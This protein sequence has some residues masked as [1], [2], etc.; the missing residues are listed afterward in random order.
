M[1]TFADDRPWRKHPLYRGMPDDIAARSWAGRRLEHEEPA[2][3]R[4]NDAAHFDRGLDVDWQ[5]PTEIP[6]S[7][8]A[9]SDIMS[10]ASSSPTTSPR[11][12]P[13]AIDD[14]IV[15]AEPAWLIDG[16][17]PA[18]GLACIVGPPKSGKSFLTSDMVCAVARG[19][20]YAGRPTLQ[21]P[22]VY[23]TGEGLNG[24]KRRL[25]AMRRHHEI[26]GAGTPF[27]MIENVP[28]L[29][30]EQTDLPRLVAELDAFFAQ[31]APD[32]VRAI[33]LDTLA[34]CMGEADENSARDMGRFIT[35][36]GQLERRYNCLIIIVHHVGKDPS[37]GARGSN[38]INGA[39]DV[40]MIVEKNDAFSKVR[41]DEMKDGREGQEWRFRLVPYDLGATSE[42]GGS[43][44][45]ATSENSTCVV[46][47][48]SEPSQTQPRATKA[49]KPPAGVA[50][51]LLKVIRRAIEETGAANVGSAAVPNNIRA[52]SRA[53]VKNFCTTMAWQD[54]AEP[55][56]FRAM[57]SKTLSQLRDKGLIDFDREC[58]WLT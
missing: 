31:R 18:R 27:Y 8:D 51:D 12:V 43:T 53:T 35:R 20:S 21:G 39:A 23:L 22:A 28:D 25:V 10:P 24:F 47:I 50:G 45:P 1:D 44:C 29:G 30:S 7:A 58:V 37:R 41:I 57:M 32:G 42:E 52:V 19:V 49:A 3:Q 38:S 15:S 2:D 16:L 40:T 4:E 46:E 6:E 48:L 26:E 14:V 34:R 13:V 17:L 11:F 9:G 55:N 33:V 54:A 56:A 36:C 5:P